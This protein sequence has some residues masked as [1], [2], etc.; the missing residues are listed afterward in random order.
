LALAR[1]SL[2]ALRISIA[3]GSRAAFDLFRVDANAQKKEIDLLSDRKIV[4]EVQKILSFDRKFSQASKCSVQFQF[5]LLDNLENCQGR[6]E[7]NLTPT[8]SPNIEFKSAF[9]FCGS[10]FDTQY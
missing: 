10:T 3:F 2:V 8:T 6:S 7:S 5:Y 1:R 9:H 4:S